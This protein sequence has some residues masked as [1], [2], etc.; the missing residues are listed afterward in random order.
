VSSG[1]AFGVNILVHGYRGKLGAA[2]CR[3][4]GERGETVSAGVDAADGAA[5]TFPSFRAIADCDM[6]ADVIIDASTASAVGHVMAYA[7][8]RKIPVV[9]CT[10]GLSESTLSLIADTAKAVAVFRS[11]NMSLG[12]NLLGR[13][14]AQAAKTLSGFDIEIIEKHHGKKLD[15]PSG[16]ALL[17]ADR[18]NRAADNAYDYKYGRNRQDVGRAGHEIGLHAVRGGTIVGEHTVLFAGQ[19]ETLELTHT[20]ASKDVF[21]AGALSAARFIIGKPA[22]LY[23]MDDLFREQGI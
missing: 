10:T 8:A 21:A 20:A 12:I 6:P 14:T 16:T 1:E 7:S 23:D 11:A 9:V 22:G 15:S 19:D 17:L 13:L 18:I 5:G 4:A 2:V 3:L